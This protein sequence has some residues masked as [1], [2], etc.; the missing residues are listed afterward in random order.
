MFRTNEPNGLLLFNGG[1]NPGK[2]RDMI[3]FKPLWLN[4][5]DNIN[6]NNLKVRMKQKDEKVI[7][8]V[9]R[10]WTNLTWLWWISLR[11]KPTSGNDRATHGVNSINVLWVF[12]MSTDT[13][14]MKIHKN[15]FY[16]LFSWVLTHDSWKPIL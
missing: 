5:N 16:K 8:C 9:S 10:I 15:K 1:G 12:F 14:L 2:V 6:N 4:S 11:L 7:P 3:L 13:Y